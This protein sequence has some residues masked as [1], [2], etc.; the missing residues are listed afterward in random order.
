[1]NGNVTVP[2]R[3]PATSGRVIDLDKAKAAR[4]EAH[5]E[6]PTLV[7]GGGTYTLPVEMPA[8][9]AFL[10]DDG[11][12]REAVSVLLGD[13]AATFFAERPSVEDLELFVRSIGEVYGVTPGEAP[14]S[15]SS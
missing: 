8:D 4:A 12:V 9:F 15:A 5:G 6:P 11:E 10:A 1:M 3:R 13:D 2:A 7:W 14:A